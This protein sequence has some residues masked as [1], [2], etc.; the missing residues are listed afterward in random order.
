MIPAEGKRKER[1]M[2]KYTILIVDDDPSIREVLTVLLESEGYT[3]RQAEN[4]PRAVEE[5]ASGPDID[6][7]ILDIMMPG[8]SGVE[9]CG[10][11]RETSSVPVLFLTAKSRDQDKV[12]AYTEGGDDYLVKPFSR[13]ELL[14]KVK[15][16]LRRYKEYQGVGKLRDEL[17]TDEAAVIIDREKREVFCGQKKI[18]LTDKEFEIMKFFMEHRG[19]TLDNKVLYEGVWGE[20]YLPSGGN[21][22]MVHILKLRRKLEKEAGIFNLIKTV[23][24][25]GYKVD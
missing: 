23:W 19:E 5:A 8:M 16:L 3:V 18:P 1:Y 7:V 4:G 24:G 9:V 6:L 14:M 20:K 2:N 13:T 10:K 21:T 22:V 15:S 12:E 11:I 25:K 17:E